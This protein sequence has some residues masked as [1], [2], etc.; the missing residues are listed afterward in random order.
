[1]RTV[2]QY[3]VKLR[4]RKSMKSLDLK[5]ELVADGDVVVHKLKELA[6]KIGDKTF[7][8]YGEQDKHISHKRFYQLTNSRANS[9]KSLGVEKGDR[10]SRFFKNPLITILARSYLCSTNL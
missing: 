5:K 10:V 1:M 4:S 2:E 7:F 8:L 6:E 3:I 9:L